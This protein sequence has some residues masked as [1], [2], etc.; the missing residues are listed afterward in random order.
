MDGIKNLAEINADLR[1]RLREME[2]QQDKVLVGLASLPYSSAIVIALVII[3]IAVGFIGAKLYY[4][5][6]FC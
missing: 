5:S 6:F 3:F 4:A 2:E 1:E